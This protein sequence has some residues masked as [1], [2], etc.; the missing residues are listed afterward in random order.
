MRINQQ[1]SCAQTMDGRAV[2]HRKC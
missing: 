1:L 2:Y